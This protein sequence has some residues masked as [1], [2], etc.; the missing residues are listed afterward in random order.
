M[1]AKLRKMMSVLFGFLRVSLTLQLVEGADSCQRKQ[2]A[3]EFRRKNA[4]F[5]RNP[6]VRGSFCL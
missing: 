1:L 2:V 6:F 5:R 3:A 4:E